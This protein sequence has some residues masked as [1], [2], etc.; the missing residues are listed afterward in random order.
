[1]KKYEIYRAEYA[2]GR[3]Y[4]EIADEYG[5]SKQCVAQACNLYGYS[6]FTTITAEKCIYVNLR[7]WMNKNRI[8]RSRLMYMTGLEPVCN[9]YSTFNNYITGK[10]EPKKGFIDK[11]IKVTGLPYEK[12]F[13]EG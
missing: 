5:V 10:T 13:K 2:K 11:L 3:T 7:E 9:N 8:K 4:Q 12:L 6:R 1:M